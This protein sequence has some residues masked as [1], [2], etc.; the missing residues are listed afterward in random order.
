MRKGTSHF[1]VMWFV[2]GSLAQGSSSWA[3]M[4]SAKMESSEK[5]SGEVVGM[6]GLDMSLSFDLA[7]FFRLVVT[8]VPSS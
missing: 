1:M 8:L 4:R 7:G 3:R 6:Y 5:D 2:S